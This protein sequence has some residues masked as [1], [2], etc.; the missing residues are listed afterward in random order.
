M[1]CGGLMAISYD[2]EISGSSGGLVHPIL[3]ELFLRNKI[4]WNLEM[5]FPDRENLW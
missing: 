5:L 1:E 3:S 2:F 4:S